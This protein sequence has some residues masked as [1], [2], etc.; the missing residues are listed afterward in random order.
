[1]PFRIG[2]ELLKE[3][4][5]PPLPLSPSWHSNIIIDPLPL[6]SNTL[7]PPRV[8]EFRPLPSP[9]PTAMHPSPSPLSSD[10]LA[11][12]DPPSSLN[13]TLSL[14]DQQGRCTTLSSQPRAGTPPPPPASGRECV[15]VSIHNS[16]GP[17]ASFAAVDTDQTTPTPSPDVQQTRASP[18]LNESGKGKR[19][20]KGHDVT[21]RRLAPREQLF[22]CSLDEPR[23]WMSLVG[24]SV[25]KDTDIRKITP[26]SATMHKRCVPSM[27]CEDLDAWLRKQH[28]QGTDASCNLPRGNELSDPRTCLREVLV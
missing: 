24:D 19:S 25:L 5:L 2:S 22:R 11:G 20:T 23:V 8:P 1:M 4:Q 17:L 9:S 27:T 3:F 28:P 7:L 10:Q 18:F 26:T 6:P 13:A 14:P 21:D 12:S 16:I 15:A